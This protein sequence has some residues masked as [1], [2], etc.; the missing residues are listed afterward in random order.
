MKYGLIGWGAG[1]VL[2]L[3]IGLAVSPDSA[4]LGFGLASVLS[5]T[6]YAIGS[7]YDN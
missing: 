4:M 5:L 2:A 7:R 1:T 6:G 3:A